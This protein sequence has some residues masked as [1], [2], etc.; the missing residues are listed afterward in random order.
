MALKESKYLQDDSDIGISVVTDVVTGSNKVIFTT[1]KYIRVAWD[2]PA[3]APNPESFEIL[4]FEGNDPSDESTYLYP[5]I[6]VSGDQRIWIKSTTW[7]GTAT[8]NA[9]VRA[10]YYKG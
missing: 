8:L 6:S 9:A 5:I 10:V 7:N 2:F 1:S 4:V 3:N